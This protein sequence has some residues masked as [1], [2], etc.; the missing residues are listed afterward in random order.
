MHLAARIWIVAFVLVV[1]G[2]A[3]SLTIH[4]LPIAQAGA[5]AAAVM[6]AVHTIQG[7]LF[8]FIIAY[9]SSLAI[10]ILS[11]RRDCFAKFASV[12]IVSVR[13]RWLILHGALLMLL[14]MLSSV[15]DA[16]LSPPLFILSATARPLFAVCAGLA[17]CAALAPWRIWG[18]AVRGN[19]ELFGYAFAMAGGAVLA[20]TLSQSLWAP[21]ARVTFRLVQILLRP[22]YPNLHVDPFAQALAT[23]R[24][25]VIVT[26]DC[27]GLEGVGLMLVFCAAWLWYFRDEYRFPRALFIVPAALLLIF[28][29]NA[30]RIAALLMI[31]DAGYASIASAGFHSQAGW[32]AFN[33]SAF[34]IAVI[35]K[36]SRWLAREAF[37]AA[38]QVGE[39]KSP[40][41]ASAN[42]VAPYLGPLATILAVGM[43]T[44]AF[45]D[46]IDVLYPLK[47]AGGLVVLW[48]YRADYRQLDWRFSWRAVAVG[49]LVFAVWILAARFVTTPRIMPER[50]ANW[51]GGGRLAWIALRSLGAILT[52]PLA[53]ELAFRGYL[54][55][56]LTHQ[57]F[58]VVS[59][60]NVRWPALTLTAVAFGLLH[61]SLWWPALLAGLA[62]GWLVIRTDKIGEAVVAHSVTN[63][64]L[65]AYVLTFGQWQ[66]W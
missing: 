56:R 10:L 48:V 63:A 16:G 20:V 62:Y 32:I 57:D 6:H 29:L 28:M 61:G 11:A 64:W 21:A 49:T 14:L 22:F 8:R 30:V 46:G 52:V 1:E 3:I 7:W 25:G 27:S 34:A 4:G 12:E 58:E 65:A 37:G 15:I 50:L 5:P 17:L 55:R 47:F 13:K 41:I 9:G 26:D 40:A 35:S 23:D 60:R 2:V 54:M 42:P 38:E 19:R 66:L 18:P 39:S 59:F 36:R 33:T 24:F 43:V 44:R 31:G 51:S 53:E 45:S